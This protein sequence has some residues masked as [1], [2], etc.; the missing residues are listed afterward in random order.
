MTFV[1]WLTTDPTCLDQ[2]NADVVVL[3]DEKDVAPGEANE[4]L[5]SAVTSVDAADGDHGDAIRE[6]ESLLADAGWRVTGDWEPVPTGYIAAVAAPIPPRPGRPEIGGRFQLRMPDDLRRDLKRVQRDGE[7]LAETARRMLRRGLEM[8]LV[9]YTIEVSD[10]GGR[11]WYAEKDEA[12]DTVPLDGSTPERLAREI[13]DSRLDDLHSNGGVTGRVR[14]VV[15]QGGEPGHIGSA[16]AV[17]EADVLARIT[18]ER[19]PDM[20]TYV[21]VSAITGIY[22]G[23]VGHELADPDCP[24]TW[25]DLP[26]DARRWARDQGYGPDNPDEVIYVVDPDDVDEVPDDLPTYRVTVPADK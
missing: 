7:S 23:G 18:R 4:P 15:W 10:D 20:N 3:R 21:L 16:I 24:I 11:T 19:K 1:A 22:A 25:Q 9:T 17:V 6:A 14:V 2:D 8:E 13:L 5:F 26:E 12:T